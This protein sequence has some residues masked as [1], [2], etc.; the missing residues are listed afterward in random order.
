M[1]RRRGG[2]ETGHTV[3]MVAAALAVAAVSITGLISALAANDSVGARPVSGLG[4]TSAT[5]AAELV[6]AVSDGSLDA[7]G[8]LMITQQQLMRDLVSAEVAR[9]ERSEVR[10]FA[11]RLS[12]RLGVRLEWLH[13]LQGEPQWP[14]PTQSDLLASGLVA[15]TGDVFRAPEV[16]ATFLEEVAKLLEAGIRLS[17][18]LLTGNPDPV[19][20]DRVRAIIDAQ[21][22]DLRWARQLAAP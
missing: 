14:V 1:K 5:P 22:A 9:G 17:H 4:S 16:D 10:V 2:D 20:T 18:R 11:Q 21:E 19:A 13:T 15:D 6:D 3:V 7:Y 12:S 8:A